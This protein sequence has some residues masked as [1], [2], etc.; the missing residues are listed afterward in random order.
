MRF[1]GPSVTTCD[2]RG[3]RMIRLV[4]VRVETQAPREDREPTEA[5]KE[6]RGFSLKMHYNDTTF[7]HVHA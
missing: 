2:Q 6:L 4:A 5:E 3:Y 7:I 1:L